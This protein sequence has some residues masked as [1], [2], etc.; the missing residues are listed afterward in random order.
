M[1]T[2]T[3]RLPDPVFAPLGPP[4][5][6]LPT[7]PLRSLTKCLVCRALVRL[8]GAKTTLL[9]ISDY[10]RVSQSAHCVRVFLAAYGI[11]TV[12]TFLR[13]SPVGRE[14]VAVQAR[15]AVHPHHALQWRTPHLLSVVCAPGGR[16]TC[17]DRMVSNIGLHAIRQT[18]GET[19]S[20]SSC[21]SIISVYS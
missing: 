8:I 12:V 21:A 18:V 20:L 4:A 9:Q 2:T 3:W 14:V 6:P 1:A 10:P 13:A 7:R 5:R 19:H 17:H 16:R 15:R 11:R